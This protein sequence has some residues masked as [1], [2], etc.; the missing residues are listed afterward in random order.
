MTAPSVTPMR[1]SGVLAGRSIPR[2]LLTGLVAAALLASGC[3]GGAGTPQSGPLSGG[4]QPFDGP[5]ARSGPLELGTAQ[6]LASAEPGP[7]PQRGSGGVIRYYGAAGVGIPNGRGIR[8]GGSS[9]LAGGA[10]FMVWA[11]ADAHDPTQ[12]ILRIQKLPLDLCASQTVGEGVE[13]LLVGGSDGPVELIALDGP[14]ITFRFVESDCVARYRV[15]VRPGP[16]NSLLG[17]LAVPPCEAP[18][19]FGLPAVASAS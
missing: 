3:G 1:R 14:W 11:G 9:S 4:P 8:S 16:E 13:H 17:R 7:C 12:G 18:T 6:Q 19:S 10:P 15:E 2:P 5:A